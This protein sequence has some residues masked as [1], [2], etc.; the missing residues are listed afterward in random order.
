MDSCEAL[1]IGMVLTIRGIITFIQIATSPDE[2]E[3]DHGHWGNTVGL[4]C[5][6]L[7]ITEL[8]LLN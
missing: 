8:C 5:Q 2:Q 6:S 4:S 1:G 7:F 3:A